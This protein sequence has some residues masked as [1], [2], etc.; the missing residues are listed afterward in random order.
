DHAEVDDDLVRD[1]TELTT[2][3]CARRLAANRAQ[4]AIEAACA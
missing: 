3:L 1:V 4:R 2:S